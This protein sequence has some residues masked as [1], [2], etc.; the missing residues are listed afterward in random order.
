MAAG[1]VDVFFNVHARDHL[2][3]FLDK[4]HRAITEGVEE[5]VKEGER[6]SKGLAPRKT[7]AMADSIQGVMT[8]AT[9]GALTVGTDHWQYTEFGAKPHDITGMVRFW[10]ENEGREWYPDNN[11]IKHPGTRAVHFMAAGREAMRERMAANIK[12]RM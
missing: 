7:S 10:W 8:S 5:T 11:V 6:V 1:E 4:L 2:G 3:R 9:S 12:S